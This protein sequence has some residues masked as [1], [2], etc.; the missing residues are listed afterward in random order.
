MKKYMI[1]SGCSDLNRGDQAL[2]WETK[3]LA[4]ESGFIGQYYLT[5]ERNEPVEQSKRKG[6]NI[7]SPI[8]EHPSRRYKNKGNINYSLVLKIKWGVVSA[9]DLL[10]SLLVL[11]NFTRNIIKKILSIKKRQS[12]EIIEQA[13]AVFM[14]GGGLLQTYGGLSSTYSMYFW[15][16]PILLA[17]NLKKPVYVMPNSFGPLKGPFVK[18]IAYS[19]LSKCKIISSRE[20]LSQKT[21]E[22][23]LGLEI[24]NYPDLAFELPKAMLDKNSVFEKYYLPNNRKLVAITMRPYRFPRSDN[25]E[26]AYIT[27]KNEMSFFIEWLYNRGYMPV[28]V[29]HTLAVNTHENDGDCIR[30]VISKI[31][32]EQYRFISDLKYDCQDLK[33]IY[34]Y[35]QYI[36]GTRFHSLIFAFGSNVPG[37]A[38][39][40]T[41]NK[42]IGIMHDMGL[43]D[44]VVDIS[45]VTAQLLEEKFNRLVRNEDIVKEKIVHYRNEALERR[46]MLIKAC[47]K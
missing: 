16:F 38:I 4:E 31:D 47:S 17:H 28:I 43:D 30:D 33:C 19:A 21:I 15:V 39:S 44:Y 9:F 24:E 29:E 25:P 14:K 22:E 27:F 37:I 2:V 6:I 1:I 8:L 35:C 26:L 18:K 13:D 42:A 32:K 41:G 11:G 3:R 23:Q 34:S 5:S 36:V 12:I 40:Y 7:I 10:E 20:T 46:K 45:E